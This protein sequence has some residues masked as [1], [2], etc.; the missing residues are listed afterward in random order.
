MKI[1]FDPKLHTQKTLKIFFNK[2]N[3]KLISI[4]QNLI[5]KLWIKKENSNLKKF[6]T[7][8][9]KA[10]DQNY[11]LKINKLLNVLNRKKVDFQFISASENI[12]WLLNIRGQD[13][14]FAPMPN[15]YLSL[16][17]FNFS[18]SS[19]LSFCSFKL[20]FVSVTIV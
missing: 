10:V 14:V 11:R 13:S 4:N 15:S 20:A 3:C 1:G 6:Y 12:A 5:D 19:L 16:D 2:T 9:K 7:L 8:P 17:S 18:S